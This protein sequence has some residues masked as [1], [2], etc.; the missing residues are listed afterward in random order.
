MG[1]KLPNCAYYEIAFPTFL[2]L[3][4]LLLWDDVIDSSSCVLNTLNC[5]NQ[6]LKPYVNNQKFYFRNL[7]SNIYMS[8]KIPFTSNILHIHSLLN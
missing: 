1:L 3:K 8:S 7:V 5:Q 4:W 6:K 2:V